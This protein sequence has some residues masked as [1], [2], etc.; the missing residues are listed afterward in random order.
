MRRSSRPFIARLIMAV[1][2]VG[3]FIVGY[4]WGNQFQTAHQ[5][6]LRI[7]GLLLRPPVEL[8][9]LDLHGP[10]GP[11]SRADLDEHWSLIA[12]GSPGSAAGHLGVSRLIEIANRI[13]DQPDLR[14]QL[15][16][17]LIS[18]DDAPILARDFEQLT[19]SL[20]VL[21]APEP[22]LAELKD[23]LGA[24]PSEPA[25]AAVQPPPLF[26]VDPKARLVTLFAGGQPAASV[27]DDLKMLS[28]RSP[29]Q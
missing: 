4:Q 12:F 21:S 2:A 15:Q 11:F 26:L 28:G 20:R 7:N 27:A 24:G 1:A 13:A 5:A 19:P 6:P 25:E 3:L 8:P 22:Q 29:N 16:L 17:L 18:A 10:Q 23:A 9:E 14:K